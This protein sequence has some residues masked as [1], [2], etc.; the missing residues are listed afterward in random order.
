MCSTEFRK[1]AL[2]R[3]HELSPTAAVDH[4]TYLWVFVDNFSTDGYS[5]GFETYPFS[6]DVKEVKVQEIIPWVSWY[7]RAICY[8]NILYSHR[9][10]LLLH[11]I[12]CFLQKIYK[13]FHII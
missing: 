6:Y 4:A 2:S 13:Y 3:L 10:L 11:R 1:K 7:L 5:L 12:R 8:R 9:F